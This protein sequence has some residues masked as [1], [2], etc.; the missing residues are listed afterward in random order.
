MHGA[1]NRRFFGDIH[2]PKLAECHLPKRRNSLPIVL[3]IPM[4][5]NPLVSQRWQ[6]E[7]GLLV[8]VSSFKPSAVCPANTDAAGTLGNV[9]VD[10]LTRGGK[11]Y[12]SPGTVTWPHSAVVL[13]IKGRHL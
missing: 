9:L 6:Q 3:P 12:W 11:E 13:D 5:V 2:W 4:E 7:T 8:G 10:A 1:T